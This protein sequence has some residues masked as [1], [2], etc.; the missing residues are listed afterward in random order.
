MAFEETRDERSVKEVS[1][2][3]YDQRDLEKGKPKIDE[4]KVNE[5]RNS[6]DLHNDLRRGQEL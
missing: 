5:I 1:S 2:L 4:E 3:E 6:F